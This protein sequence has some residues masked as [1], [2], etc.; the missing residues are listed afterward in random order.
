[1]TVQE[2]HSIVLSTADYLVHKSKADKLETLLKE[3]PF[4]PLSDWLGSE[5]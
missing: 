2:L 1:M 5:N 3:S 4:M